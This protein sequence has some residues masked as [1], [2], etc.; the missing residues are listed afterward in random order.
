ML[1]SETTK[2]IFTL[3]FVQ[4]KILKQIQLAKLKSFKHFMAKLNDFKENQAAKLESSTSE[5][6]QQEVSIFNM[7]LKVGKAKRALMK[8]S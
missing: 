5:E 6:D 8:K 3:S 1:N 7:K 2:N 4:G